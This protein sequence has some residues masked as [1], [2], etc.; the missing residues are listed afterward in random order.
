[1]ITKLYLIRHAE[2]DGNLYR[3]V[4]GHYDSPV[5]ELGLRQIAAL[6]ERF[7]GL[8]IDAIYSSDLVRAQSTA[9]GLA[10][11]RG[12]EIHTTPAL[13]E[14]SMG[15]WEDMTWASLERREPKQLGHFSR[16]PHNWDI[17]TNE[18]F[19]TTTARIISTV[20]EIAAKHPG[21]TVCIVTHGTVIRALLTRLHGLPPE[22][23]S[24]IPHCDNTA[25][26]LLEASEDHGLTVRWMNNASHLGDELSTFARQHW[27]RGATGADKGNLDFQPMDLDRPESQRRYLNYRQEAWGEVHGTLAGFTDEYVSLAISHAAA[28]PLALVEAILTDGTPV[29]LL[30][31]DVDRGAEA[32][33]GHISFFYLS[34][35]FRDRYFGPQ[36]I[37]HAVSVY[38]P[39]GRDR[40]TLQVAEVNENAIG[41]YQRFGFEKIGEAEGV[42]GPLWVME[43]DIAVRV[44]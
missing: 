11:P 42:R 16:E 32:G 35:A 10:V 34:P 23:Y 12:L 7:T 19:S 21:Q 39:L 17:G 4:H 31:L 8:K 24:E 15:R 40:L 27:W 28:H 20:T 2:A 3:R 36:L 5:T 38:R 26:T 41:F 9:R 6:G 44:R 43:K 22:R 1:M 25:V 37:G 29:G 30:E 14:V 33:T 13:R 18:P